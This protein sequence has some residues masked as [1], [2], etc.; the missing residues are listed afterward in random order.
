MDEV[1]ESGQNSQEDE[2][3]A[4]EEGNDQVLSFEQLPYML[5]ITPCCCSYR[6]L[7]CLLLSPWSL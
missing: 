4:M 2:P 7:K 3:S 5:Y 6:S 1:E